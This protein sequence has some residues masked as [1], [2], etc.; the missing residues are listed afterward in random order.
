MNEQ[1][2]IRISTTTTDPINTLRSIVENI[3]TEIQKTSD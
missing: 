1:H 3:K 2:R